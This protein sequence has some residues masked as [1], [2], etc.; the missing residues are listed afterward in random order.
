MIQK[1]NFRDQVRKLILQKMRSGQ[2][3][4]GDSLSLAA[5]ARELDVS[6]TPIREALTQLQTSQIIQS[7]PNRGFIIPE[8]NSTEAKD[9][10]ELVATL[11]SF[12]VQHSIYTKQDIQKLKSLQKVFVNSTNGID[13]INA[14]FDFHE[15]LTSKYSNAYMSRILLDTK[16]RIFF[17]EMDF[18]NQSEFNLD[19]EDHHQIIIQHLE[20]NDLKSASEMIVNNW[21]LILNYIS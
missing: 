3:K 1:T 8:L 20:N 2:L 16:T 18:M 15:C 4:A 5:L 13:R 17:Y 6:V 9:L 19:S 10:Y 7:I 11:E 21:M 12:I 14:D